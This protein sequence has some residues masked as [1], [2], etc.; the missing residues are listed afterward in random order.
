MKKTLIAGSLMIT[1]LTIGQSAVAL[2]IKPTGFVD[3]VWTL[4]DGTDLG[5]NGAEGRFDTTGE[6]DVE[7]GLKE[8]ISMRFDADINPGSA[9]GDSGRLEQIYLNWAID[10]R[11]SLKGGVFNNNLSWEREDAPDM[12]QITHGQLWDIWNFSTAEDGNNLAGVE[13]NYQ[14][15][16]VKLIAGFLNDLGNVPEEN[17]VKIAGEIKAMPDLDITLGLITQDQLFENII[18]INATWKSGKFLVGGEILFADE[19]VDSAFMAM[20]NYKFNDKLSG[21]A[22]YDLVSYDSAFLAEDTS[23]MTVAALYSISSNLFFNAEI[24]FNDD[25]NVPPA[26][27]APLSIGEGDGTTG[28]LELLATF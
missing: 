13:F 16:K 24:R 27:T 2:D 28:R 3:M 21:T 8:G 18:D 1:T 17:S 5:K 19:G 11:M 14:I 26:A 7:A 25:S 9:G 15:D 12:Y 23:S 6:L 22:R 20:V 4:S 10:P